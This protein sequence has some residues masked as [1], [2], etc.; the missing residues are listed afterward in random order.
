MATKN[1]QT[2]PTRV[3]IPCRLSF[4]HAFEPQSINGGD[5]KYSASLI[6]PNKDTAT[7]AAIQNAVEAAKEAGKG[8]WGGKIPVNLKLPLRSGEERPDDEAYEDCVF[9]NANNKDKP[10][11]VD[12]KVR[13][14]TDPSDLVSGDYAIV[15]VTFYAFNSNGNRGIAASLGNIQKIRD[16]EP[17]NGRVSA[18]AEFEELDDDEFG[19]DDLPDYLK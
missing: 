1:N 10:G 18:A 9:L 5:P 2:N 14:I 8:K 12:R 13:P 16:G 11:I 15:S 19:E 3:K 6:I 17:L 7:I 4:L